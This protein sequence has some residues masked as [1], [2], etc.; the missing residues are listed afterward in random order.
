MGISEASRRG[1][2][3]PPVLANAAEEEPLGTTEPSGW[4]VSRALH[5]VGN[6]WGPIF[7]TVNGWKWVNFQGNLWGGAVTGGQQGPH[8]I[9]Q[10]LWL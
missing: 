4:W 3:E 1:T 2:T 7:P 8:N 6:P 9:S 5:G 10:F